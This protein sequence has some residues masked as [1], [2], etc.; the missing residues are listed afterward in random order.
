[1]LVPF[2][3]LLAL[4][5]VFANTIAFRGASFLWLPD[6]SLRDPTY[7]IPL[8]MGGSMWALSKLGQMGMPPNPQAKMMTTVMPIMM[9]VLFLN[10]ASGLNLYYAVSNLVSLPQQYMITKARVREMARRKGPA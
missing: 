10:F 9:T 5:F 6:L 1:M 7:V 2:P 4:F 3:I 8:V